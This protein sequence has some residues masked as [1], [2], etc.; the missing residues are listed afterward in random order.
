MLITSVIGGIIRY[1]V[2]ALKRWREMDALTVSAQPSNYLAQRRVKRN[3]YEPL[4]LQWKV[5]LDYRLAGKK[6]SEIRALTGLSV[7]FI[8]RILSDERTLQVK[9]FLLN[10][11]QEEFSCLFEDVVKVVKDKLKDKEKQLEAASLWL[12]ANGKI[13]KDAQTTVNVT[14]EDVVMQILNGS[15]AEQR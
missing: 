1:E 10:Q 6:V 13:G 5:V 14:A 12:K 8:Y 4:P 7:P 9:Q 3:D 15:A 2:K 11:T